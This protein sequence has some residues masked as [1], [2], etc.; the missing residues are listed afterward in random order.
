MKKQYIFLSHDVDWSFGGPSKEHVLKRKDRFDEKLFESIPINKL[1]RN[2]SEYMEIEEKFHVKSTFFFR[3]LYENGDLE[4]YH[5]DIK[6]LVNGGWEI[7]L[8]TDPSS[9]EDINKIK[10]EKI[11]LE[12]ITNS[13]IYG[14][15]VHYLSNN[16]ELP[17]KLSELDFI[18]DSS[19]KKIKDKITVEDM[20]YQKIE[21]ILEF[22]LTI[23]DAYLFTHM[24]ISEEKILSVIEKSL[25]IS[26]ESNLDFNIMTILWHDNVLKMKGG[27][28]YEKILEFFSNQKDVEMVNGIC[29]ANKIKNNSN[30]FDG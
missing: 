13:K 3:T 29:L 23:M 9:I 5:S 8:H 18:Y 14:N 7:G 30:L 12:K 10:K 15:R 4:D 27:R 24:K 26:R 25:N 19:N 28:M 21:N 2:F 16:N 20:G 22:P 1:Y 11:T 17:R 6:D